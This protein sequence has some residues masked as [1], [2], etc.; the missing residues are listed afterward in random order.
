MSRHA[1]IRSLADFTG[2]GGPVISIGDKV[3]TGEN[4]YPHYEVIALSGE[5]AWVRDVQY[6][7]DHVVPIARLT[8][9]KAA[10]STIRKARSRILRLPPGGAVS[11]LA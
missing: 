5:R 11:H 4:R 3:H 1:L 6:G 8:R 9:I 10:P 2:N 7:T